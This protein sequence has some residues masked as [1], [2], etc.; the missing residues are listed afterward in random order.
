MGSGRRKEEK[1]RS[2]RDLRFLRP[3]RNG[4]PRE[5]GRSNH[6]LEQELLLSLGRNGNE[7]LFDVRN[8]DGVAVRVHIF[9]EPLQAFRVVLQ[10]RK[11][12]RQAQVSHFYERAERKMP[13]RISSDGIVEKHRSETRPRPKFQID[14]GDFP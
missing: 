1:K 2:G 11:V 13:E 14:K 7:D 6:L 8:G 10:A 9:D 3:D 12:V 4:D 5:Q